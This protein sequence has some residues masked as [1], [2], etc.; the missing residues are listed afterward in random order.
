MRTIYRSSHKELEYLLGDKYETSL[1]KD[2]VTKMT[3]IKMYI[4]DLKITR[5]EIRESES[6][7]KREEHDSKKISQN[8]L[9]EELSRAMGEVR[10]DLLD[11]FSNQ[12]DDEITRWNKDLPGTL[13]RLDRLSERFT[14]VLESIKSY[15]TGTESIIDKLKQ[16]YQRLLEDKQAHIFHLKE[17]TEKRE[18]D[19][20]HLINESK[21]NI[22]LQ[23]FKGYDSSI[24][25]YTFQS[26]FEKL[27]LRTTPKRLLP[28]LLKNNFLEEPALSIIKSEDNIDELWKRLKLSYGNP[29]IMLSRK[30]SQITSVSNLGRVKDSE[31]IVQGLSQIINM[32]K[33]L[34]KLAKQHNIENQLYYG[35]ALARIYNLLGD[36]RLTRWLAEVSHE[37]LDESV[38]WIRLI[39]FLEKDLRVHQEKMLVCGKF[40]EIPNSRRD[41]S[42]G[43]SIISRHNV[44]MSSSSSSSSSSQSSHHQQSQPLPSSSP[45]QSQPIKCSICNKESHVTTKGPNGIP[46][47]Q[48]FACKKFVEMQPSE[49]YAIVTQKN[50]CTQYL[51][52]RA[53]QNDPRHK[54]GR[55]Q[56]SFACKHPDHNR[57]SCRKHVLLCQ[58]HKDSQINKRLLEE[59]KKRFITKPEYQLPSFSHDIKLSYLSSRGE[60]EFHAE[61]EDEKAIYILQTISIDDRRYSIFFDTGCDDLVC[62]YQAVQS[63]GSRAT[64]ELEG[65]IKLG[66]VGDISTETKYG[67]YQIRLPLSNGK[68][69]N[70]SGVCVENITSPFPTYPLQGQ[71]QDD[72]HKAYVQGGGGDIKD[73]PTL[74]K[75]VGGPTD[76]M[77]GIK[78]LRYHPEKVFNLPS[79][80]TIYRSPFQNADG[81]F[82]VV[83]GPHHIFT[84]ID[85][86]HNFSAHSQRTFFTQQ[87]SLYRSFQVNPD[88]SLLGFKSKSESL[89]ETPVYHS[90]EE[91]QIRH[92]HLSKNL[93]TFNLI[94]EAGSEITFRCIN[95]RTCKDCKN[96]QQIEAISIKEEIEQDLINKSVTVD[97]KQRTTTAS[98]PLLH[99]P[100]IKLTPNQFNALRVYQQQIKKLNKNPKDKED[101]I[102]S[103]DKLQ[104]LGYVD[105][106]KNLPEHQQIML[107]TSPIQN[108]IPWR[109]VWKD[110]SLSTPC[111]IVFDASQ[112]TR[113]GFSLNDILAKGRNNMNKL[114]EIVIRWFTHNIG[115]HS[116]AQKMYNAVQLREQDWCL[117]RYLWQDTLDSNIPPEEKVIKTLIYGVKSSG[118]QAERGLR[119]TA[120]SS[121]EEY[122]E[123]S[124]IVNRDVY[125]DDCMSGENTAD[126]AIQRADQL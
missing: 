5:K 101:V 61:D 102:T 33:D 109:A 117:Q 122:P 124:E 76:L 74:G 63:L 77:I 29:K 82:G 125:V 49:R 120:N 12:S 53:S 24:D 80:L 73:L 107:R 126:Q 103:Q 67:I 96:H 121:Q 21:L 123:V 87:L 4:Q 105:Y 27:Y 38:L 94:E 78:Y 22:K 36:S 106:V 7:C 25:I 50:L 43:Q 39:D 84:E 99:N 32:I 40:N 100:T 79:G 19:K 66:G 47:V 118:N 108:F 48:Y 14:K 59:Y 114:V 18:L 95:C 89:D 86:Y 90:E 13:S 37:R 71:V 16:S 46:V 54:E 110:N 57:F 1:G 51:Y 28:D 44:H 8:F 81:G 11:D 6:T 2:Y 112:S 68:Y 60:I 64:Q 113:S 42:R 35:D 17:E 104:K 111:R 41:Q 88:I 91:S 15:D 119:E 56:H 26:E 98:L 34:L 97:L 115:F 69:A 92:V 62:R 20:Q 31:R 10:D 30:L 72:I 3:K 55:C 23:K 45:Q 85:K 52:P 116:D 58:E 83:G 70:L 65:P 9:I 75:S 93:K